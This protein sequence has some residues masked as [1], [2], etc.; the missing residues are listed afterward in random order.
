MVINIK[1]QWFILAHYKAYLAN[2]QPF[3]LLKITYV[4]REKKKIK[5]LFPGCFGRLSESF[6]SKNFPTDPESFAYPKPTKLPT[7][8][9]SEF[10][11]NHLGVSFMAIVNQPPPGPRTTPRN[12][13]L[14]RP[15]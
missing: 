10:L 4:L 5:L 14:I 1:W 15:Y 12:K 3:E 11:G 6:S 2:G 13:G 7:V 8:Y 9:A